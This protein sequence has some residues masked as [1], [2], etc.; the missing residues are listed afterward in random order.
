QVRLEA[1]D[2]DNSAAQLTYT[3]TVGPAHGTLLKG[4]ITVTS[5]TQAD[6]NGGLISYQHDGS[7]TTTDS[8]TFTVSDGS[9]ATT[10]AT[11]SVT[12]R[13]EDGPVGEETKARLA[14]KQGGTT[15]VAPVAVRAT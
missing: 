11:F 1:T 4:G 8:F 7:E 10:P 9:L 12:V 5:F 2:V 3:V 13:P 6:I 14:V 15:G